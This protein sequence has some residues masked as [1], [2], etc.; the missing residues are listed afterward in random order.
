MADLTP[1]RP[2]APEPEPPERLTQTSLD[3]L[4]FVFSFCATNRFSPSVREIAA[5]VGVGSTNAVIEMIDRLAVRGLITRRPM[6]GRSFVLTARGEAVARGEVAVRV[7]DARRPASARSH[8]GLPDASEPRP[9]P[10][11]PDAGR[12]P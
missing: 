8:P 6:T 1:G 4:R 12:S 3:A 5:A 2:P 9:E 7:V 10:S 11:H